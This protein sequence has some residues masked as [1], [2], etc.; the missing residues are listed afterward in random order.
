MLLLCKGN[1]PCS[2]VDDFRFSH[3]MFVGQFIDLA[4]RKWM[5]IIL[6]P[7]LMTEFKAF[8]A[9][10]RVLTHFVDLFA[11]ENARS[12]QVYPGQRYS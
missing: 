10:N 12:Y 1:F 7:T 4:K 3:Y 5:S 8:I 11:V 2:V 9:V 6:R